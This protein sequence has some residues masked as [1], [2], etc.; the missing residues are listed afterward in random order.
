[1]ETISLSQKRTKKSKHLTM[2]VPFEVFELISEFRKLA[3]DKNVDASRW[4]VA[5]LEHGAE[6]GLK[7]LQDFGRAA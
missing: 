2:R 4:L 5:W 1:M 7:E 3:R 6:L